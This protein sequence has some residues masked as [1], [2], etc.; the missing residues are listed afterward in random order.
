MVVGKYEF[1]QLLRYVLPQGTILRWKNRLV[2]CIIANNC[3]VWHQFHVDVN[4]GFKIEIEELSI[5][6]LFLI[7]VAEH[8][9][10]D[11]AFMLSWEAIDPAQLAEGFS[12]LMRVIGV[13]FLQR[14]GACTMRAT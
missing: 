2:S 3:Q 8:S 14:D 13:A 9:L 12:A 7:L 6:M 10:L 11:V 4:E 1:A 5:P